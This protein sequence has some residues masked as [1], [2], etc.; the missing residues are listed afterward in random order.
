MAPVSSVLSRG[1]EDVLDLRIPIGARSEP[2]SL[3]VRAAGIYPIVVTVAVDGDV[4]AATTTLIQV[5][6]ERTPPTTRRSA[7]PSPPP[8]PIPAPSRTRPPN[9]PPA[10]NSAS[11]SASATPPTPPCHW[12]SPR[13]STTS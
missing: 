10:S 4:L 5:V 12:R 7:S 9:A 8:S 3:A 13:R 1:D 11:W 2:G 6:D